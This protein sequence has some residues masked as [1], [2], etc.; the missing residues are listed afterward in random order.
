MGLPLA[1]ELARMCTAFLLRDY[2]PPPGH[3]LTVY[4][5]DLPATYPIYNIPH[6]A[7]SIK[8]TEN[9][10]TQ[11]ANYDPKEKKFL[12]VH[13]KYRQPVLLHQN[14]YHPS[15]N[16]AKNTYR[17]SAFRAS[18]IATD[19]TDTLDHRLRKYLPALVRAGHNTTEVITNLVNIVY[20]LK[21]QETTEFQK[22]PIITYNYADTRPTKNQLKPLEI[23][24]YHLIPQL[25]LLPLKVTLR[26]QS[27]HSVINHTI[28]RCNNTECG[29]CNKYGIWQ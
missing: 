18:T 17:S 20:F 11:D 28:N 6:Q 4:F 25:S 21:T 13:Q 15:K 5:E 26:N 23:K 1:P 14:S 3:N 10:Q 29:G 27:P 16:I 12:P 22:K 2:Q 7:Y 8:K 19:P 9:N 24:N